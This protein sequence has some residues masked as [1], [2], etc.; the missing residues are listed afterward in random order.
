[1]GDMTHAVV[2]VV[3]KESDQVIQSPI[4][5]VDQAKADLEKIKEAAIT[6]NSPTTIDLS[7]LAV[8]GENVLSVHLNERHER[9]GKASFA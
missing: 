5:A 9:S 8:D 2:V 3:L 4:M 7:W 6:T 1:M